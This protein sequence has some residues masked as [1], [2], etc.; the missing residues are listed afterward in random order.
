MTRGDSAVRPSGPDAPIE[1]AFKVDVCNRRSLDVGV[2][3]LLALLSEFDVSASFFVTFG[4][5]NSGKAIRRIF[6][7]GFMKKMI[8]TRA[9]SMYGYRTLLY[10]TLL[11]APPVGESAPETLR[12]LEARGHEVGLHS[13]DHVGWHDGLARMGEAA[14]R[15]SY[16]RGA[17]LFE[18]SVGHPPRFS[19]AAGW[20]ATPVSLRVQDTLG[21]AFASDCRCGAPFYPEIDG[22]R[23]DTLQLPTALL[24]SDEVLGAGQAGLD[25]LSDYYLGRLRP[26]CQVIGLHAEAE[27]IAFASWLRAFLGAARARGVR[28]LRLSALAERVRA[29]APTSPIAL[30]EIPGRAGRVACPMALS[31]PEGG[32]LRA[33]DRL[34]L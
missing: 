30:C 6:R 4:P 32:A 17:A 1:I 18:R 24:T 16:L 21:F 27:G 29:T 15:D 25:G 11:P 23:L 13:Y 5:D 3:R 2:P 19:G 31:E 34:R 20:H 7:R 28:F 26:G 14:V 10:G 9:P 22:K 12:S 33:R 8:R